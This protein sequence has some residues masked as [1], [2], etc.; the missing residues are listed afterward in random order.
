MVC[1]VKAGVFP[2]LTLQKY[3]LFFSDISGIC[4]II[5]AEMEI[6]HGNENA[7]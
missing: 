7:I 5:V 6:S 3:L 1:N 4:L 2:L